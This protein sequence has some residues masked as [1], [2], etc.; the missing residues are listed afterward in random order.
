MVQK[1]S[2]TFASLNLLNY[3]APPFCFYQKDARYN[4]QVWTSKQ[5]WLGDLLQHIKPD[6]IGFQEVFSLSELEKICKKY[7]LPY[8]TAVDTPGFSEEAGAFNRPVCAIAARYPFSRVTT[9]RPDD[10]VCDYFHCDKDSVFNRHPVRVQMTLPGLGEL[11]VYCVH[12]KS[13]RRAAV[14]GLMPLVSEASQLM[15]SET[16]GSMQSHISR[17]L[18]SCVLYYDV[19]LNQLSHGQP[20]V[21]LGDFNNRLEDVSLSMLGRCDGEIG[22]TD[23][24]HLAKAHAAPTHYYMG[25][26]NILDY[27]LLSPQFD[28]N[29]SESRIALIEFGQADGHLDKSG[30]EDLATSDHAAIWTRLGLRDLSL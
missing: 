18:E 29:H 8:F 12:F 7:E 26:G 24:R 2:F 14:P 13:Q 9:V 15:V 4:D 1:N 20:S 25:K 19:L 16:L 11:V 17:S 28:P 10:E 27:I 6:V 21:V 22:L 30:V 5:A 3:L 23:A